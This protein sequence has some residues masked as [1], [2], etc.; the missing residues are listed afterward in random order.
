M[1]TIYSG[2]QQAY[3]GPIED[4][5]ESLTAASNSTSAGDETQKKPKKKLKQKK[6]NR[7]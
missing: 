5:P 1:E 2:E 7:I 4:I 6:R 3:S